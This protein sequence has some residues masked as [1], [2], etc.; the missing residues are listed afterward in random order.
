LTT[1]IEDHKEIDEFDI[2]NANGQTGNLGGISYNEAE[3]GS[4]GSYGISCWEDGYTGGGGFKIGPPEEYL[5]RKFVHELPKTFCEGL[6]GGQN[7]AK[8]NGGFGGGGMSGF[9]GGGGY[10]PVYSEQI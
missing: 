5:S 7:N 6:N 1:L 4:E 2:Q 8:E 10:R 9:G 3:V